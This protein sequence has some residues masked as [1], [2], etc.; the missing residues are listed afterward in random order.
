MHPRQ[1][2]QVQHDLPGLSPTTTAAPLAPLP[3]RLAHV[4]T[5]AK[6]ARAPVDNGEAVGMGAEVGEAG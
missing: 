5:C 6:I 4:Y 2:C 1:I 3:S